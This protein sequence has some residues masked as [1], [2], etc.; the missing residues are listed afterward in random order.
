MRSRPLDERGFTVLELVV[1]ITLLALM[2][3]FS[4]Q[5]LYGGMKAL[6][7]TSQRS[8][9]IEIAN[10]EL[11]ALRALQYDSIGVKADDPR[12][13]DASQTIYETAGSPRKHEGR[14]AVVVSSTDFTQEIRDAVPSAV[15]EVSTSDIKG[16]PLPY[17]VT[18]WI[19]W[20]TA[21]PAV[22]MA[23]KNIELRVQWLE[24]GTNTRSVTLRSKT[25]PGGGGVV[26]SNQLPKAVMSFSPSACVT[27]G[28]PVN[29]SSAGSSDPEGG[30]LLYNWAFGDGGLDYTANPTHSYAVPN[31][32]YV[33][34]LT[35]VDPDGG[36]ASTSGTVNVGQSGGALPTYAP[37]L[38][39]QGGEAPFVVDA[40][41]NAIDMDSTLTYDWDWGDGTTHA[42][43]GSAT[44]TYASPGSYVVRLN[45]IEDGCRVSTW[46]S[47][48]VVVTPLQCHVNSGSFQ[49]QSNSLINDIKVQSD[50]T[51]SNS[52]KN[53]DLV[54]KTTTACAGPVE[55][56]IPRSGG[57]HV[58]TLTS[59]SDSGNERTWRKNN[60][61]TL[62][63]VTLVRASAQQ[64][65]VFHGGVAHVY[66]SVNV[67]L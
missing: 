63:G 7:A 67:H 18:R 59:F 56:H 9:F 26:S 21:D 58:F 57:E 40:Q 54:V 24:N 43:T 35:V 13:Q 38:S 23:F 55:V 32:S 53:F 15:S 31:S 19:T 6:S 10:G 25:Y 34:R 49:Q 11:E 27:P 4:A 5:V 64:G 51:V 12:Y 8:N 30:T 1:A 52:M 29:F 2:L 36:T 14:D 61:G 45:I 37:T 60:D 66:F 44:H 3:T 50:N 17:T 62:A 47:A 65:S 16:L 39:S 41:A 33:A 22:P 48:P 28:T 46:T 42:T 20:D